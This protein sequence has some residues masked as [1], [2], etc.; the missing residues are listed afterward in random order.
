MPRTSAT[1]MEPNSSPESVS[2]TQTAPLAAVPSFKAAVSALLAWLPI[3]RASKDAASMAAMRETQTTP[4]A[5]VM[6][7]TQETLETPVTLVMRAMQVML[8]TPVT[9]AMLVA[10]TVVL[11]LVTTLASLRARTR[12]TVRTMARTTVKAKDFSAVPLEHKRLGAGIAKARR[13][14][15]QVADFD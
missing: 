6:L 7:A 2:L 10:L 14:L 4:A 5:P 1:A 12:T 8:A 11:M 9:V 13:R 15:L 3:S